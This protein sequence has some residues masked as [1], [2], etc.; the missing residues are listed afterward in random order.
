MF[1]KRH[2]MFFFFLMSLVSIANANERI[3]KNNNE[4]SKDAVAEIVTQFYMAN[5]EV[6]ESLLIN[7]SN[8]KREKEY[9]AILKNVIAYKSELLD[10]AETPFYGDPK[11]D[12]SV[13]LFFDYQCVFC[14]KFQS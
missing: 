13:I 4:L 9:A 6:F 2:A 7:V 3:N 11:G 12:V 14:S 1:F 5:P 8:N 10:T